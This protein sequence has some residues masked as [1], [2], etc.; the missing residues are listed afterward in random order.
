MLFDLSM[1]SS[2]NEGNAIAHNTEVFQ[3]ENTVTQQ[4]LPYLLECKARFVP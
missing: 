4:H 2:A 3:C 1:E